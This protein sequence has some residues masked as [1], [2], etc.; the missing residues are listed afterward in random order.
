MLRHI[1]IR[2]Y[3]IIEELKISFDQGANII[4]GETGAGKSILLGALA[5]LLGE[6]A[7]SRAI[8]EGKDKCIIEAEF[9]T[10]PLSKPIFDIHELDYAD[11]TIIRREI[12]SAGKSR[13]FVNDTPVNLQILKALGERLVNMHSQHETLD[14]IGAGMQLEMLDTIARNES[15]LTDYKTR[16]TSYIKERKLLDLRIADNHKAKAEQ[17][18]ITFQYE[19]LHHA[20]LTDGE[21]E[22][23]EV[24]QQSLTHVEDIQRATRASL[25]LLSDG[26]QNTLDLL[27]EIQQQLKNLRNH[28][29]GINAISDRI[30]QAA[31]EIK[32]I[33]SELED[34]AERSILD[35]ERL[36]DTSERLNTLYRLQ[37]KHQQ[38]DTS[39]LIL[40]RDKLADRL[41]QIQHGDSDIGQLHAALDQQQRQLH[42]LAQELHKRR[43]AAAKPFTKGVLAVLQQAGMPGASFVVEVAEVMGNK[44]HA[45]GITEVQ[46]LFSANKGFVPQPI[47]EVASGGELSRLMLAIKS[48]TAIEGQSPT[49]VFD[50][51]DTGISGETALRVGEI[52]RRLS[53]QCQL[54]CI[55]HL[56]QIARIAD[57]HLYLYKDATSPKTATRIQV[58]ETNDRVREIAKMLGGDKISEAA[59]ANAKQLIAS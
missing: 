49:L 1:S 47:R 40:L 43:I 54:I 15:L 30:T 42:L 24:E 34:V 13:A 11:T 45:D 38:A 20:N 21:Q 9:D 27:S 37:K 10:A 35:P 3:A 12:T 14:L 22:L 33:A 29:A 6:R 41:Q 25:T 55:T 5:L 57:R 44:L 18:F 51:I 19:E 23:L 39:S 16:Y 46:F 2:H 4:T 8:Y 52:M 56:P 53:G 36:H 58:L 7:D 26:E 48:M 17:D 31:I 59:L 32:D 50:E 28:H